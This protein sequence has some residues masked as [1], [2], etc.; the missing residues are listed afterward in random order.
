MARSTWLCAFEHLHVE[1]LN[2]Q[3]YLEVIMG[4][5]IYAEWQGKPE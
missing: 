4:I 2:R 3:F 1:L 5:D